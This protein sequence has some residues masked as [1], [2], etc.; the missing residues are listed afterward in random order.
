MAMETRFSVPMEEAFP[1]G[2]YAFASTEVKVARDFEKSTRE[3]TVQMIDRDTELP[4]WTFDVLDADP[5]AEGKN[6]AITVR[7][8]SKLQPTLPDAPAGFPFRPVEFEGLTGTPYV[9]SQ[10]CTGN[11]PGPHRCRSR[12]AWSWRASGIV[13][14]QPKSAARGP[15]SKAAKDE[16]AA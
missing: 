9:D 4:V 8:L 3:N 11:G 5:N 2:V 15:A 14:P 7:I 6:A 16:A 13:A 10:R 12:L 1:H